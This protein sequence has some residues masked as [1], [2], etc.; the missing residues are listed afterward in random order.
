MVTRV[1]AKRLILLML[2]PLVAAGP[3]A[4]HR[5]AS[6][7]GVLDREG[8]KRPPAAP[9]SRRPGRAGARTHPSRSRSS[10][11][12][13]PPPAE[14]DAGL[15]PGEWEPFV[16]PEQQIF[17]SFLLASATLRG[18]F[19]N[20]DGPQNQPPAPEV[21]AE[22]N[23]PPEKVVEVIGDPNG[24]IG[25]TLCSPSA[26]A[27]VEL[28]VKANGYMEES[29]LAAILPE[30]GKEYHLLPKIN[31]KYDALNLVHQ[32]R[33]VN[34]VCGLKVEGKDLGQRLVTARV[35]PIND[36]PFAYQ[37]P[38]DSK[39]Y[40]DITWMFAAYVNEDDPAIP[41]L[42]KEA[43]ETGVVDG[44]DA[45]QSGDPGQV[46]LQV[47]AVWSAL[48]KHGIKYSDIGTTASD[49]DSLYT[50]HVR[51][52]EEALAE[53]HANCVDASVLLASVLRRMGIE[54][55]L[56]VEPDH[57]F[58][59]FFLDGEGKDLAFLETTMLGDADPSKFKEDKT[60][61]RTAS[62]AVKKMKGW[63]C[64]NNALDS[65]GR[66]YKRNKK[67]YGDER[68]PRYSIVNIEAA[69]HEGVAPIAYLKGNQ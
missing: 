30:A 35:R 52:I 11:V 49:S 46:L 58:L 9:T 10:Q 50:M 59:G 14:P 3:L 64:F 67:K 39:D 4:G 22:K 47:F 43:Q 18:S 48:Q 25:V 26:D 53:T 21:S 38:D 57:M 5:Q 7:A 33:P 15:K 51:F 1:K 19:R 16:D 62:K 23:R 69:R 36:C 66:E 61:A 17:P 41:G 31:Y 42:L 20:D 32:S 13:D 60:L 2:L 27:H 45:Y 40:L 28:E 37:N 65:A 44:F 6:A 8:G 68:Q 63:A 24:T 29:R 54:P 12:P 55:F 34:V 56:L